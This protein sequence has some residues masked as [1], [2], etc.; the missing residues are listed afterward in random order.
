MVQAKL[1]VGAADDPYERE[2]DRVADRVVRA[3]ASGMSAEGSQV[4]DGTLRCRPDLT[5]D[6]TS[7]FEADADVARRL[8]ARRGSGR[9]LP[10]AVRARMEPVFGADF[11]E[12]R[13]HAD[14]EAGQL[15]RSIQAQAFTHGRDIYFGSGAYAPSS[16]AGQHLLAHELAHV[17]Q[18]AGGG[19]LQR[20]IDF[21]RIGAFLAKSRDARRA[22]LEGQSPD[23][24][25]RVANFLEQ[26]RDG[27]SKAE[28]VAID[29]TLADIAETMGNA[30]EA[31][32]SR[33]GRGEGN[34]ANVVLLADGKAVANVSS[35]KS[36]LTSG[37]KTRWGMEGKGKKK[38]EI[39]ISHNDSEATVFNQLAREL[40]R[41]RVRAAS[42]S[43]TLN[44]VSTNGA[45]E[46]CKGRI[47]EFVNSEI[48]A[49]AGP[50]VAV[51]MRYRYTAPPR[52]VSRGIPTTY[53]WPGDVKNGS[54]FEHTTAYRT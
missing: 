18:Q 47:N 39:L 5:R 43:I 10:A 52:D 15:S 11:G 20:S 3:L 7:A 46:G 49:L 9:P 24:L 19:R 31:D 25:Q 30:Q 44:F 48:L 50:G 14:R 51:S 2:A 38:K 29:E 41:E 26:R 33:L 16:P 54:L 32:V 45:C 34:W 4:A 6:L 21:K 40:D 1:T 12:V 13:V 17:V 37:K 42:Q 27:S 35:T 22:Q 53:G 36:G 23:R 28:K 8:V